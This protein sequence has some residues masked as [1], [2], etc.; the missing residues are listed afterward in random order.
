MAQAAACIRRWNSPSRRPT[1]RSTPFLT[2][3]PCRRS[4]GRV[5]RRHSPRGVSEQAGEL[6]RE[7]VEL[8]R[9]TD[10][11]VLKAD[12]LEDLAEV[13]TLVGADGARERLSEAL[14][15]LERKDDVVST[16]RVRASLRS[17]EATAA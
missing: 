17:L 9:G 16:E 12:A 7:A 11:L 6:A 5:G 10:A 3:A 2:R 15:L 13:L 4:G 8:L 14:G 1:P